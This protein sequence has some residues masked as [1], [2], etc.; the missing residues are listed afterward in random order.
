MAWDADVG[1]EIA[2]MFAGLSIADVWQWGG[3]SIRVTEESGA[4]MDRYRDELARDPGGVRQKWCD[5]KKRR[6]EQSPEAYRAMR[7][8][9]KRRWRAKRRAA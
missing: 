4:R 3:L 9:Q 1:D 5:A 7:L 2:S 8:E 6:R